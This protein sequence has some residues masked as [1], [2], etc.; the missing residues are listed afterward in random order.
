MCNENIA[1]PSKLQD[2]YNYKTTQHKA[3]TR[4]RKLE[5]TIKYTKQ[6]PIIVQ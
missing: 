5:E 4:I 1:K 6:T 3:Q 2:H